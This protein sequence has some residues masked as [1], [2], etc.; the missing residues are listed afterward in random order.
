MNN[1]GLGHAI[2]SHSRQLGW[3]EKPFKTLL[4][5]VLPETEPATPHFTSRRNHQILSQKNHLPAVG[6][7]LWVGPRRK[8]YVRPVLLHQLLNYPPKLGC[9]GLALQ[10][11]LRPHLFKIRWASRFSQVGCKYPTDTQPNFFR[12][13]SKKSP[14]YEATLRSEWKNASQENVTKSRNN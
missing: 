14:I 10:S 1:L 4:Q 13:F 8:Y 11:T 5:L 9:L 7:F 2:G 3:A 6:L 12:D